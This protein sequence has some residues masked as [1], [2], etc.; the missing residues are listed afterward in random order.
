MGTIST[1]VLIQHRT[2]LQLSYDTVYVLYGFLTVTVKGTVVAGMVT[3]MEVSTH[4]TPVIHPDYGAC[5]G[6]VFGSV[7]GKVLV[8][9]IGSMHGSESKMFD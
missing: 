8:T 2:E 6:F 1:V 3:V 5:G 7:P 9:T 4:G